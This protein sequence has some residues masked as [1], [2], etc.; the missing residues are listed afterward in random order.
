MYNAFES[1]TKNNE[2]KQNIGYSRQIYQS[3]LDKTCF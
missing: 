3:K 2:R 1:F